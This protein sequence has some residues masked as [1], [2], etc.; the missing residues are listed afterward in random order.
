MLGS[1]FGGIMYDIIFNSLR[2]KKGNYTVLTPMI[3]TCAI[4]V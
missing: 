1:E 2:V 3:M 4:H